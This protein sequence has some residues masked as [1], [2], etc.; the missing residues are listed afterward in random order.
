MAVGCVVYSIPC[1]LFLFGRSDILTCHRSMKQK[2]GISLWV[3]D[4]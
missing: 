4:R 3:K 2:G 1:G